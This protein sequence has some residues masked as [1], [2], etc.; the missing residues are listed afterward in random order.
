VVEITRKFA[1]GMLA[2]SVE[3]PHFLLFECLGGAC[4]NA[5]FEGLHLWLIISIQALVH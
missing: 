2:E 4:F 1:A 5:V 3:R